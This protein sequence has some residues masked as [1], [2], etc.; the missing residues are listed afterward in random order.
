MK[1]KLVT[2]IGGGGFIGRYVAQ[3]LLRAGARVR[4]AQRNPK[5]AFF[6]KP[7]GGLGQTQ[8]IAIDVA[9]PDTVARAV[10]GS[11]VVINLSGTWG[12]FDAVHVRGSENVARAAAEAGVA[13]LIHLSANGA[14]AQGASAYARSKAE[15][16]ARVRAAFAGATVLRPTVV[17]GREDQFTNR[18]AG[19]M[20][21]P[22]VPV[23][24]AETKFQPVYVVDVADA[25]A[26]VLADPEAHA[27]RTYE[28]GGPDVMTMRELFR[29]IAREAGRKPRF[30][31]LSD[32]LGGLLAG[33]PGTPITRDQWQM[34]QCDTLVP[35][36]AEG[37]A[38]L[39]VT[40]TPFAAVAS[41]WLVRFRR[42]G[43]FGR[44]SEWA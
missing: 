14:D 9:R 41:L 6:L 24:R 18:F 43:R 23:L 17:F 21:W 5:Q 39:G 33:L 37:L 8:F 1:D 44:V 10:A 12:D 2:L 11:D 4:I 25:V 31:E 32:G 15:G 28:L 34:L 29:A 3:D 38:A 13:A 30:V 16:E 26:T 36:G 27:G 19:M 20:G 42:A 40:P 35:E 7:L 22:V